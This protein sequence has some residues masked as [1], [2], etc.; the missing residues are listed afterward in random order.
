MHRG[1]M[2]WQL[3]EQALLEQSVDA[4]PVQGQATNRSAEAWLAAVLGSWLLLNERGRI[5]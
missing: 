1:G 5:A 3:P 2:A 4:C